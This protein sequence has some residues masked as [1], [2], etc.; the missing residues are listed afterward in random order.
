[1][2]LSIMTLSIMTLSIMTLSIMTLSITKLCNYADCH[3][4]ECH[5]LFIVC[6]MLLWWVLLCWMS[7]CWVSW[8]PEEPSP[9]LKFLIRGKHSSLFSSSVDD[10]EKSFV[11]L[12]SN[13]IQ[14]CLTQ[15]LLSTSKVLTIKHFTWVKNPQS[16]KLMCLSLW[17]NLTQLYLKPS[18]GSSTLNWVLLKA[19]LRFVL[20]LFW[21]IRLGSSVIQ[22]FMA[23]IYECSQ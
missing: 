3:F 17:A 7:L 19:P 2:T 22:L 16:S 1:M 23:V 9:R 18:L 13:L 8:R 20:S 21:N 15:I 11:T 6:W 14:I 5:D 4:T 12:T 10:E